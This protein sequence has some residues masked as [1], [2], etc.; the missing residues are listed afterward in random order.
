MKYVIV[1]GADGGMGRATV[2]YLKNRGYFVFALD[3]R[4]ISEESGVM[5]I[6]VDVTRILKKYSR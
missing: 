3:K 2:K 5:P 4:E 6:T 1:T